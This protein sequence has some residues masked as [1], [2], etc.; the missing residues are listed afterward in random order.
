MKVTP[1]FAAL[2]VACFSVPASAQSPEVTLTGLFPV[3]VLDR[4]GEETKGK[5]VS[6]T[7]SAVVLQMDSTTRTFNLTDVVRID[8][9]GDSMKNG[10]IIGAVIGGVTGALTAGGLA[11]CP[12]A[13]SPCTGARVA[14]FFIATG[15]WTAIGVGIDALI[16]GRTLLWKPSSPQASRSSSG[17]GLTLNVSPQ[18]RRAFVGWTIKH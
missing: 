13:H 15:V 7:G 12:G 8:R 11:D 2:A 10:A 1:I 17:S 5:L 9:Q 6:L 4:T 3:Y 16:P 14:G 18:N